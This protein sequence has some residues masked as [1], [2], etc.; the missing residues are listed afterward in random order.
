MNEL[1]SMNPYGGLW[2]GI[3][4]GVGSITNGVIAITGGTDAA[5]QL[6]NSQVAASVEKAKIDAETQQKKYKYYAIAG[7]IIL[8]IV[9]YFIFKA[10]KDDK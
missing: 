9:S 2:S 3:A 5:S 6:A 7:V 4:S 10:K 1:G 8:I